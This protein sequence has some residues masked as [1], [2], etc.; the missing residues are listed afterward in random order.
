MSG[1]ELVIGAAFNGPPTSGNGGYSAGAFALRTPFAAAGDPVTVTL[2]RPPPLEVALDITVDDD[3]ARLLHSDAV[4]AEATAGSFADAPP[5]ATPFAEA[6]AA[7]ALYRGRHGHAFGTCFTCG[8][9]RSPGDGLCLAPG[10]VEPGR[11]ACTWTPHAAHGDAD[12]VVAPAIVWAALDCPSAWTT[13]IMKQPCVL[14]RMTAQ[15]LQPVDAGARCV[16]VGAMRSI[17]GRK[18]ATSSALYDE[19][20]TLLAR[21]E[22]LWIAIDPSAFGS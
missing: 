14:G 15:L 18:T 22:H 11:T 1:S 6:Q 8:P 12:G 17:N 19:D 10:I 16:V 2:R 20:G 3:L 4:V 7:E 13:D 21:A 9:D 5:S